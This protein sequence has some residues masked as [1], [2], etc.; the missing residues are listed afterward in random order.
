MAAG[1]EE[2]DPAA[3]ALTPL[4]IAAARGDVDEIRALL[5][6][7]ADPNARSARGYTPLIWAI[8]EA[9]I[10]AVAELLRGGADPTLDGGLAVQYARSLKD[11]PDAAPANAPLP[12]D[13]AGFREDYRLIAFMVEQQAA[14]VELTKGSLSMRHR[15]LAG[16]CCGGHR[17][18]RRSGRGKKK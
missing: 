10:Y 15:M 18:A 1:E 8:R 5:A 4:H 14:I 12:V 3:W 17:R 13:Y 11:R 6:A 16:A 7:R 2:P 9:Q